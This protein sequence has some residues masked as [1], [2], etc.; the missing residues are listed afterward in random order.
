M[1]FSGSCPNCAYKLEE[2][3]GKFICGACNSEWTEDSIAAAN[4]RDS[5]KGRGEY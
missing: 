3:E 1:A 2:R 4:K 5:F